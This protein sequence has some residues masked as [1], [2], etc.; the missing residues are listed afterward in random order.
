[1]VV[2]SSAGE[3]TE[4]ARSRVDRGDV[5]VVFALGGDGTLR[6]I[7][8]GLLGS[9]VAFAPLPG[10][11]TNVLCRSF[12]WPPSA[13]ALAERF[14]TTEGKITVRPLDVAIIADRPF[15]MMVS[16]GLDARVLEHVPTGRKRRW[17]KA[18]IAMQAVIELSREVAPT[19]DYEVGGE[20][21]RA[22]FLSVC[23]IA[24]YGGQFVMAPG[25]SPHDG[26]LLAVS[27]DG[28]GRAATLG[29]VL[30]VLRGRHTERPDVDCVAVTELTFLGSGETLLQIDGDPMRIELPATARLHRH[31]LALLWPSRS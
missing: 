9:D 16:R 15:L 31:K 6:E 24:H 29:F 22:S 8:T 28:T 21:M 2:T 25:A 23:N 19:F 3:G 7:A 18:G 26:R 11:T 1:M 27:F 17:G 10:G 12:G 20:R 4:L 13:L 5:K 14:A 30:A